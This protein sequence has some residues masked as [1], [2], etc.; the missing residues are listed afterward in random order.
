M[1]L[2]I[3]F[4]NSLFLIVKPFIIFNDANMR[5]VMFCYIREVLWLMGIVC[6]AVLSCIKRKP[7]PSFLFCFLK[8]NCCSFG[9]VKFMTDR[10]Y[11][12]C[13]TCIIAMQFNKIV[14]G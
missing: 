5:N 11:A 4:S 13:W 6:W 10:A 1:I 3:V 8:C 14:H 2:V 7:E 9:I 12:D